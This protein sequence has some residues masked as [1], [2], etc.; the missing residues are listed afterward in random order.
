MATI[1]L[2]SYFSDQIRFEFDYHN[3]NLRVQRARC[4][5]NSA[6]SAVM[7]I[8]DGNTL[9]FEIDLPPGITERNVA[10]GKAMVNAD[11]ELVLPYD[12]YLG[13]PSWL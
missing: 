13:W 9:L 1:A 4:I 2:T 10:G 12:Y 7:R 3:T 11:G 5:N 6:K 8:L